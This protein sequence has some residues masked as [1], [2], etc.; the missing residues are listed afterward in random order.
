MV[1]VWALMASVETVVEEEISKKD[2][3]L[4]K[5][6]NFCAFM[7]QDGPPFS[8][9]LIA[10]PAQLLRHLN[11]IQKKA[12][13]REQIEFLQL[14]ILKTYLLSMRQ[15]YPDLVTC[16]KNA[17]KYLQNFKE[18]DPPQDPNKQTEWA[19]KHLNSHDFQT[20]CWMLLSVLIK[21][22]GV[23]E[24][25]STIWLKEQLHFT[26]NPA[27]DLSR[28]E[29]LYKLFRYLNLFYEELVEDSAEDSNAS[30]K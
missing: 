24:Q 17:E 8:H 16:F 10:D 12:L 14:A 30:N 9:R 7:M 4:S 26:T 6:R 13:T 2:Y 19:L 21:E 25:E 15:K 11:P 5:W 3:V 1:S 23:M 18:M 20:W 27:A 28:I 29:N 22:L